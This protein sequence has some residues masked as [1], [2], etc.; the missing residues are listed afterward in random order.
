M[1]LRQA[2]GQGTWTN[3]VHAIIHGEILVLDH[4]ISN[5]ETVLCTAVGEDG[6]HPAFR[7]AKRQSRA[8]DVYVTTPHRNKLQRA[9][10]LIN[11]FDW[12]EVVE[13]VV[14]AVPIQP[15]IANF[16]QT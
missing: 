3:S 15:K 7:V 16:D 2:H 12:N 14:R 6:L 9:R 11:V 4:G 8:E 10:T 13:P 1:R 5:P